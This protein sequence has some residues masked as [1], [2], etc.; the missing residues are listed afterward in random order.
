MAV[1]QLVV[2][3]RTLRPTDERLQRAVAMWQKAFM[4]S[5]RRKSAPRLERGAPVVRR[6]LQAALEELSIHGY[7]AL[8]MEDVATR[9]GVNKTTIYRRWPTKEE[10]VRNLLVSLAEKSRAE[11]RDTGSLEG[12]LLEMARDRHRSLCSVEGRG[13]FRMMTAERAHPEVM[14]IARAVQRMRDTTPN[15]IVQR[16][17]A[18]GELRGD[19]DV[20]LAMDLVRMVVVGGFV[21][22]S[23]RFDEEGV[24][25]V[26][27]LLLHGLLGARGRGSEPR[28][29]LRS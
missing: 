16:G 20:E 3:V 12:D 18:R 10:L 17:V 22:H 8:R 29:R 25:R 23:E 15:L 26:L 5:K 4:S 24:R 1:S 11:L 6:V 13:V 19:E 7:A 14:A 27:K 21:T 9:A 28:L 2:A